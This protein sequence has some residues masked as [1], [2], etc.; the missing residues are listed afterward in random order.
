MTVLPMLI[1][2]L[3]V[4]G[5][6]KST[7]AKVD[8]TIE[9]PSHFISNV[10]PSNQYKSNWFGTKNRVFDPSAN[11]VD[12]KVAEEKLK[13]LL[14]RAKNHNYK[15]N[16]NSRTQMYNN[17]FQ[18]AKF[19]MA[20]ISKKNPGW[21]LNLPYYLRMFLI[22]RVTDDGEKVDLTVWAEYGTLGK[23]MYAYFDAL[24]SLGD[25]FSQYGVY[26]DVM[27]DLYN[28][29]IENRPEVLSD[30]LMSFNDN[31]VKNRPKNLAEQEK[32]ITQLTL[33]YVNNLNTAKSIG[34]KAIMKLREAYLQKMNSKAFSLAYE[35]NRDELQG[36]LEE[37][38]E[39]KF[40]YLN[41]PEYQIG[42]LIVPK[43]QIENFIVKELNSQFE[44]KFQ[45]YFATLGG[46]A[47]TTNI[48]PPAYTG[49][50]D[51]V[52]EIND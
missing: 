29:V 16:H 5:L 49:P 24:N 34:I 17:A 7:K 13:S 4:F 2:L 33:K 1:A 9:P 20:E 6:P 48:D 28:Y 32:V 23:I 51:P 27:V 14:K 19:P 40:D 36:F 30:L 44:D 15:V 3:A 18:E 45:K 22:K 10:L 11:I 42:K 8:G 26:L 52:Y 35:K 47:L 25:G 50:V 39:L 31:F 41:A 43:N 38:F 21:V 46:H 37:K 12:S